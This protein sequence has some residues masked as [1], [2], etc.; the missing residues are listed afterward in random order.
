[1]CW[2]RGP[3]RYEA[4]YLGRL[5]CPADLVAVLPRPFLTL[6]NARVVEVR[7]GLGG[8][9]AVQ[10]DGHRE[11]RAYTFVKGPLLAP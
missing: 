6:G 9:S 4:R 8:R 10:G 7:N 3:D 5:S 11:V 1:M 2:A